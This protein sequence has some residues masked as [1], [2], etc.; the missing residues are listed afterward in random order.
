[1]DSSA[2]ISLFSLFVSVG[3]AAY[4]Y[5]FS[6]TQQ[7][8]NE[9]LIREKQA[10]LEE[11]KRAVFQVDIVG[12][13]PQYSL[14]IKNIGGAPAVDVFFTSEGPDNEFARGLGAVSPL[15]HFPHSIIELGKTL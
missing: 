4:T 11:G 7:R 9:M 15:T 6:S 10:E 5:R 8:L 14:S 13:A 3:T 2:W 12:T 1:M